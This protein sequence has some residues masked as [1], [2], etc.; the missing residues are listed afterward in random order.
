MFRALRR[1][2]EDLFAGDSVAL[3]VVG[4][5]VG[6]GLLLGLLWRKAARDLRRED[7]KRKQR[8]GRGGK[9]P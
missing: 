4:V 1:F 2:F 8:H 6:I 7:E 3:I 9:K 5:I